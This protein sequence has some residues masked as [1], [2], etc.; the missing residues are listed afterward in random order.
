MSRYGK[1]LIW[2]TETALHQKTR[3]APIISLLAKAQIRLLIRADS[4][5]LFF[6]YILNQ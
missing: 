4:L 1:R 2:T 3:C 5:L 6:Y